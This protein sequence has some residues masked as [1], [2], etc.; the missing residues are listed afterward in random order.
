MEKS[1][2]NKKLLRRYLQDR[3]GHFAVW[4]ALMAV[5]MLLSVGVVLDMNVA[6]KKKT[7][8]KAALD[9]TALATVTK[10]NVTEAERKDYATKFFSQTFSDASDFD[11][12]VISAIGDKVEVAASGFSPVTLSRAMGRNGLLV[13]DESTAELTRSKVVCILTLNPDGMRS[14]SVTNGSTFNSPTCAV[15][16][17]SSHSKALQVDKT[18]KAAASNFCVVG[19]VEGTVS[20]YANT[21]CSKLEDPYKSLRAPESGTCISLGIK[22][23]NTGSRYLLRRY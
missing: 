3:S 5:P 12:K 19:G 10:Q 6:H 1:L 13:S 11:F 9:A 21:E 18:S 7:K 16:V 20:P 4:F 22:K 17:N 2:L 15:Q 14:F 8:L 23:N